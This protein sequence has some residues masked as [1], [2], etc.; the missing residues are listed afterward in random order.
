MMLQIEDH[1]CQVLEEA[2]DRGELASDK[3]PKILA[4]LLM[5]GIFG[6]RIYDR[7]QTSTKQKKAVVD[8]LL[9]ILHEA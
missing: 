7:V 8:N 2:Q 1:F 6:M 4:S 9:S 5:T 3:D